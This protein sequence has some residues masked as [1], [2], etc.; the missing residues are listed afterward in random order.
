MQT[1][2]AITVPKFP[3]CDPGPIGLAA[4]AAT[5]MMLSVFNA[6]FLDKSMELVVLPVALFYGG[7]VQIIAGVAELFRKNI[8]GALAFMSY[9]GFWMAFR[10]IA[11]LGLP[12]KAVG[13]FLLA[14][15]IFTVYM[16]IVTLKINVGLLVTFTALTVTFILLT[17]GAFTGTA[18]LSKAGGYCG[19]LT[20][21]LAWYCSCAGVLNATWG[22]TVLPMKSLAG[23]PGTR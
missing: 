21:A 5:T 11:G 13:L 7:A 10:D 15:T 16:T 18:E 20:A 14:F 9:G 8:F 6:G 22:R 4:F 23:T 19:L 1:I 12:G 2:D 3:V 17:F